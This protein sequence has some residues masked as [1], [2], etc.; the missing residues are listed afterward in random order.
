MAATGT[1]MSCARY[2]GRV[3]GLAVALGAGMAIALATPAVGN[4]D[5]GTSTGASAEASTVHTRSAGDGVSSRS[6]RRAVGASPSPSP[7]R[8]AVAPRQVIT[9]AYAAGGA[10]GSPHDPVGPAQAV[11]AAVAD[12]VRREIGPTARR[13]Y[14]VDLTHT[15]AIVTTPSPVLSSGNLLINSG[16]ESG[17]PSLSG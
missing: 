7:A 15:K 12:V 10:T 3:G 1:N 16:A 5:P 13:P 14:V 8:K 4:A 11:A 6:A 2:V 17:D 9:R